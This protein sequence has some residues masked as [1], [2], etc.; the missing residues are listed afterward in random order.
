MW[1]S[2]GEGDKI[3]LYDLPDTTSRQI[4]VVSY[5]IEF[6]LN[7]DLALNILNREELK[8]ADVL[9][10]QEMDEKG[11]EAM[12]RSLNMSYVY[13]PSINHP[14]KGK[15]V[16]NAILSKWPIMSHRKLKLPHPSLYPKP[17]DLK[18][19]KF[20]KLATAAEIFIHGKTV[21]FYSAHAAAFNTTRNR[22][23]I[24]IAIRD[25]ALVNDCHLCIIGGDFNSMG[26]ADI[27]ATVSPFIDSGFEWATRTVGQ[28]IGNIRWFL[29]FIPKGAFVSDHIFILGFETVRS[30]KLETYEV[31]DHG[32]VWVDLA[33]KTR[34]Y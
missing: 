12:A 21:V 5:N 30:G 18:T 24:A 6:A 17:F 13:Y 2:N 10:L 26:K 27:E 34:N 1:A 3:S 25:D 16:G 32:P 14:G 28:T 23:D 22:E 19:Y 29:S 11:T 33:I 20:R 4:K 7:I 15:K 31:S 8:G 9:L